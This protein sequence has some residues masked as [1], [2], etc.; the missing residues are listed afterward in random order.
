MAKTKVLIVVKT[1]P[2]ISNKYD[3]LVCTAG[4]L[5]DGTWIRIYPVQFRKKAFGEQYKKYDWIEIDLIKNESDFRKESYRP[6]AYETEIKILDHIDTKGNWLLRKDIVLKNKVYND[7][8]VLIAEAKNRSILTSLATFKPTEVLNFI[9]E[10]VGREW[11][12]NKL[13]KLEQDRRSN[14]FA[15]EESIFKVVRKLPYKFSYVIKD[16]KGKQSKMMIEDW[17]IGQLYWTCLKAHGGNEEKA[18]A[19]VK[20]KYFDDFAKTKDLYLFLGTSQLYHFNGKN[21]FMIIGTFHPKIEHQL[22]L[23]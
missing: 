11:D 3:E 4:F 13:A 22:S 17:E 5:E 12:K 7:L 15:Q 6:V 19:D 20:K 9:S 1:Y 16:I 14:L 10:E 2:A 23:F 18:I 21:P 8:E